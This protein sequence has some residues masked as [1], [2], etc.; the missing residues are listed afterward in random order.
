[1]IYTEA[2]VVPNGGLMRSFTPPALLCA[3]ALLRDEA[4]PIFY[5]EN[6]FEITIKRSPADK[7]L[8]A[9]RRLPSVD[10]WVWRQF[11]H[12]WDVFNGSGTNGLRHVQN[13]TLIYELSMDNGY[14]FGDGEFDKR[15]GFRFSHVPFEEHLDPNY[16]DDS[17]QESDEDSYE[18]S[19]VDS[20]E[21]LD[22]LEAEVAGLEHENTE[23]EDATEN[24]DATED[25]DASEDEEDRDEDE[26]ITQSP[27]E[28]A[29]PVDVLELN[30]GTYNWPNRRD[31]HLFLFRKISEYGNVKL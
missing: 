16:E 23:H 11:L 21:N 2:L 4:L 8:A 18:H 27:E 25:D 19:D 7:L 12:M 3:N 26:E 31:T 22:E 24:D 1:M 14:S 6:K 13:V 20:D 10:M 17:D 28:E 30:R 9:D 29:A 5:K 15:L